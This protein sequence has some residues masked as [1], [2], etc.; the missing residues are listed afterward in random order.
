MTCHPH[1]P[2]PSVSVGR[3]SSPAGDRRR[4]RRIRSNR[5]PTDRLRQPRP[6]RWQDPIE[7][8]RRMK[9]NALLTNAVFFHNGLDIAEIVR[10]LLEEG[11]DIDPQ[12]LAHISP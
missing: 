10:Q 3:T 1:R 7:Q 11:W 6:H 8:E 5:F 4:T 2:A 9:F 12:D